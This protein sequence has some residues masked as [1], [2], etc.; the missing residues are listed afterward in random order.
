MCCV[1]NRAQVAISENILLI[2]VNGKL[3]IVFTGLGIGVKISMKSM[4]QIIQC[5]TSW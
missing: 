5:P 1:S 2:F 3:Q 4:E